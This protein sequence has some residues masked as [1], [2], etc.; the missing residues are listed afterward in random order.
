MGAWKGWLPIP[1]LLIADSAIGISI[2][3]RWLRIEYRAK[4]ALTRLLRCN[5]LWNDILQLKQLGE[6]N[7]KYCFQRNHIQAIENSCVARYLARRREL[8]NT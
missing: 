1:R 8:P 7:S 3:S 4:L 2:G 5:V 6:P